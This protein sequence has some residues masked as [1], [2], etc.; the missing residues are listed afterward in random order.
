MAMLVATGGRERPPRNMLRCSPRWG[1]RPT[2]VAPPT[3]VNVVEGGLAW[4]VTYR[5]VR[6]AL[7]LSKMC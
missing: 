5:K 1:L 3:A 4:I 2:Q 6:F 7:S